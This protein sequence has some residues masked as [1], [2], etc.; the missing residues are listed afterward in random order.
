MGNFY[1]CVKFGGLDLATAAGS[2]ASG[3]KLCAQSLL[4][5]S[6]APVAGAAAASASGC[7]VATA[8]ADSIC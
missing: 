3:V 6:T 1:L 4:V 2:A 5:A 8:T 7:P